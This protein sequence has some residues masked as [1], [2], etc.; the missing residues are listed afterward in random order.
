[1]CTNFSEG[2][3]LAVIEKLC[4]CF[5][6]KPGVRLLDYTWDQDHN[7][8]VL[9]IIGEPEPLRDAMV[10]AIGRAVELIDMTKHQGQHPRMGCVDVVPFIPIRNTTVGDADRIAK[11]T[12]QLASQRFGQPPSSSMRSPQRRLTGPIWRMCA[13]ASLRAWPRR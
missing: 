1:M 4:D 10:E 3:D 7:R 6:G 2:R 9:T 13:R 8:C 5:R 12:A 11:E